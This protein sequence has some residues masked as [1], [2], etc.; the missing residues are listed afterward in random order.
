MGDGSTFG[1]FLGFRDHIWK[2][3]VEK[4]RGD[5]GAVKLIWRNGC[6]T[7]DSC[8]NTDNLHVPIAWEPARVY[9]FTIEWGSGAMSVNVCE[10]N[11]T[12]CGATLY[13][14]S[15]TGTYAPPNHRISLGCYPRQETIPGAI[16]RN[17]TITPR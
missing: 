9:H 16:Y 15:G 4:R 14:A 6:N 17:V 10:W 5:G 11:G 12:A 2:M 7:D 1:S 3:H 13:R 8:D